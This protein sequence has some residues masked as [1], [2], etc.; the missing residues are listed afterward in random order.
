MPATS[1]AQQQVMAIAKHNPGKLYKR[2]QG[3]L[4]MK[5]SDLS[6]FASTKHEGLPK[7]VAKSSNPKLRSKRMSKR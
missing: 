7:K 3:L 2:N 4:K 1:V 6:D 5:K